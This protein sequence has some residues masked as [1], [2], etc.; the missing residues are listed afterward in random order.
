MVQTMAS[1]TEL[2]AQGKYYDAVLADYRA[3]AVGSSK[4]TDAL[5]AAIEAL[6][7]DKTNPLAKLVVGHNGS[8]KI[9]HTQLPENEQA[10]RAIATFGDKLA[11][12]GYSENTCIVLLKATRVRLEE[13]NKKAD[14]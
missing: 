5:L 9:D 10:L 12:A 11:K 3:T 8:R 4:T 14:G 6:G 2:I 13:L 1:A 7:L